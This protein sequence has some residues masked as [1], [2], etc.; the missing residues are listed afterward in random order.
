MDG[1]YNMVKVT[2]VDIAGPY[3]SVLVGIGQYTNGQYWYIYSGV[4]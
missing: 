1:V 4:L 2:R 3:W